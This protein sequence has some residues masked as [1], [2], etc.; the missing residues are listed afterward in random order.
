MTVG[1][2]LYH[3]LDVYMASME[4]EKS[5]TEYFVSSW[6]GSYEIT[7]RKPAFCICNNKGADQLHCCL[8]DFC[9]MSTVNSCG[10]VRMVSCPNHTFPGQA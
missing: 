3:L 5:I 6:R 2:G 7:M 1:Q 4:A 9:L 8:F 10:H